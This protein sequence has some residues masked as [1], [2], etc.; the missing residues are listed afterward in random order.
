MLA[1]GVG[2]LL[3]G[4]TAITAGTAEPDAASL[5]QD[6]S[7][8]ITAQRVLGDFHTVDPCS[9]VQV[10]ALP[11][12]LS[13]KLATVDS[14]DACHLTV[15]DS[16]G[17]RAD[18][19]VGELE[20]AGTEQPDQA[21]STIQLG[22]GLSLIRESPVSGFC[23]ESLGFADHIYLDAT[24]TDNNT[25]SSDDGA[26]LCT[27]DEQVLRGV[28]TVLAG[29][30]AAHRD[31]PANSLNSVDP[32]SIL[33]PA[34]LRTVGLS[35]AKPTEYPGGH[36]CDWRG[37]ADA[38]GLRLYA[39]F[40]IG[41]A[42]EP[43]GSSDSAAT[44]AGRSSVISGFALTSTESLCSVETVQI[45]YGPAS[46]HLDEIATVGAESP[47]GDA[48]QVCTTARSAATQIWRKL[49]AKQ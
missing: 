23:D 38:D 7:G 6:T 15:A 27:A 25:D 43:V 40:G 19:D 17:G 31:F 47:T 8:P 32:C 11:S 45:P 13:A 34:F 18:I 48:D 5:T 49:P 28:A 29:R 20:F 41:K 30:T 14:I 35:G 33:T 9:L 16:A 1:V 37:S 4:C 12:G 2:A 26:H 10:P 24:G 42:P 36:E 22:R 46:D 21:A 39:T 3:T 44:L